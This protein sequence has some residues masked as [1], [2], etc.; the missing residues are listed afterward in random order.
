M[1]EQGGAGGVLGLMGEVL[2][3]AHVD[4]ADRGVGVPG[5]R[6]GAGDGEV[7]PVDLHGVPG[8]DVE[9]GGDVLG[10]QRP[11][12]SGRRRQRLRGLA[13]RGDAEQGQRGHG[14]AGLDAHLPD[15]Q[16]LGGDPVGRL[17]GRG[18][19]GRDLRV[20]PGDLV[21]EGGGEHDRVGREVL[22]GGDVLVGEAAGE[23][24]QQHQQQR[25]QGDH[26]DHEGESTLGVDDV[27]E[28]DE[29][30]SMPS[31]IPAR[32]I[33]CAGWSPMTR[34]TSAESSFRTMP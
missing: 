12:G 21:P 31:R 28:C 26:P 6:R 13:V 19:V 27:F 8:R 25:E 20:G 14:V 16:R 17:P 15:G 5:G 10:Q 30:G 32:D 29:H 23:A 11:A 1:D 4:V 9:V 3:G 22:D 18:L 7:L 24:G 34:R 2:E 33:A